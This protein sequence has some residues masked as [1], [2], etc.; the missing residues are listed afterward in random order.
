M[1]QG[2]TIA[3]IIPAR[4]GSTSIKNKNLCIVGRE[5]LLARSIRHAKESK[6]LDNIIV[7]TNGESIKR[8]ATLKGATVLNR[9]EEISGPKSSTEEALLHAL[10]YMQT[11]YIVVLQ[12]TSPFRSPGL[13][14]RC[15][16][17]IIDEQG[18]S[19]VACWKFHNFCFY[20]KAE[21]GDWL[22]TYD[23]Q[24]RPM[25]QDIKLCDFHYFD[26]GCVYIVKSSFL[27][28][29][30]CRLGGKIVVVPISLVETIQIDSPEE[31]EICQ[32]IADGL[33]EY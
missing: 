6:H 26:A 4:S 17:K 12:P 7:S 9:P 32:K 22:A 23:Y 14:D 31:L 11:D 13:I 25:H 33:D 1:F 16:E 2:K 3:C 20:Q 29:Q 10:Q 8:E 5:T 24:H 27:L 21:L 18:D 15:V 19:L 30:K 28:K